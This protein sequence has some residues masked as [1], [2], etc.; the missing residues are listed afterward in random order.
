MNKETFIE[1][2]KE[3]Y[4]IS[5]RNDRETS[6]Y[7]NVTE[8]GSEKVAFLDKFLTDNGIKVDKE[9]RFAF[10]S[11]LIF[12]RETGLVGYLVKEGFSKEK[13]KE[14]SQNAY[15]AAKDFYHDRFAKFISEIE[16]KKLL[17]DFHLEVFKGV[18]N[19][20]ITMSEFQTVWFRRI[21]DLNK[22]VIKKTGSAEK[23][24]EYLRTN[25][26]LD[27]GH[28]GIEADRSYSVLEKEGEGY[29]TKA[30]I[31]AF[32]EVK[33]IINE[34]KKFKSKLTELED[35]IFGQRH[36]YLDYLEALIIAFSETEKDQLVSKWADVDT[37]WMQIKGPIQIVHPLE[38]Y[39]DVL[40]KAVAPEW[41][42]RI[43][44]FHLPEN[45]R[46]AS[47]KKMYEQFF[48]KFDKEKYPK[49][50][51]E[52]MDN[53]NKVQLFLSKPVMMYGGRLTTSI[54]AQVVPNDLEVS[55]V[56]GKKIFAFAD[57]ILKM[58][59][60]KPFT[61]LGT[62]LYD[63]EYI[64]ERRRF[65][66]NETDM[67]HKVYDLETI[68]HEYGHTLWLDATTEIEMNK[69][70]EFKNIEEFKATMGGIISFFYNEDED[71]NLREEFVDEIASRAAGLSVWRDED[72]GRPYYCEGL[73]HL[74]GLF[75]TGVLEFNGEKIKVKVKKN[76]E[77]IKKW[78]LDIYKKLAEHY[79]E[80]R[81]AWDF[82][83]EFIVII[84][85]VYLPKDE[86][87]REFTTY[88]LEKY[89]EFGSQVDESVKKEDYILKKN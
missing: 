32:P 58:G 43:V 59:R 7:Y 61:K 26:L 68:G 25:E 49:A 16:K 45:I 83:K 74:V 15:L 12:L 22:E 29:I 88:F 19:I 40:R 27:K 13:I 28:Y 57:M 38:Y 46:Q 81:D 3:I 89:K 73:I 62:I 41:D 1:N 70:G 75:E 86:K 54:S 80:K 47:V 85:G 71:K 31:E 4:N 50:Y 36:E 34:L 76:Y 63:K 79:L 39:D 9:S 33:N 10:A 69:S 78:Y 64:D 84:D 53:L 67:W 35:F 23:A 17:D 72:D 2:L 52:S 6:E 11:R 8:E 82:L 24:M 21:K 65:L 5:D 18:H 14:I 37:A 87:I 20:G 77:E 30:Y 51:K 60:N 55:K 44:D 66:F 56:E 48:D 42:I